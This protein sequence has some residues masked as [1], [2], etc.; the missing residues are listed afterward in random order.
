[1]DETPQGLRDRLARLRRLADGVT[2]Q[3]VKDAI[4]QMIEELELRLRRL[5]NGDA[6]P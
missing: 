3:Q 2:D 4:A 6:G 5:E 1:L